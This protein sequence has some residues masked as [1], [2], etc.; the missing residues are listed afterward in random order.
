MRNLAIFC[1][2]FLI[3]ITIQDIQARCNPKKC[4]I[5]KKCPEAGEKGFCMLNKCVCKVTES[6]NEKPNNKCKLW[7]CQ[8]QCRKSSNNEETGECL[9]G[10]CVCFIPTKNQNQSSTI[11]GCHVKIL[12]EFFR[13][14]ISIHVIISDPNPQA[15]LPKEITISTTSSY[16]INQERIPRT[17]DNFMIENY[18][19]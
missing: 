19:E 3:L 1:V 12:G 8:R 14:S 2:F 18:A 6:V 16:D 4:A 5:T 11:L 9:A 13:K 15:I 17:H 10:K 7:N